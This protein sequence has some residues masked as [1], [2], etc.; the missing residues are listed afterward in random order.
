MTEA[1]TCLR[2]ALTIFRELGN[3]YGEAVA[4]HSLGSACRAM[5]RPE[6]AKRYLRSAISRYEELGQRGGMA[7][8]REQLAAAA[9]PEP[10]R[11]LTIPRQGR[12][13]GRT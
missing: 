11:G 10:H 1:L 5:G 9:D 2:Q 8:A 4:V 13:T 3:R 12:G 6:H 7:A